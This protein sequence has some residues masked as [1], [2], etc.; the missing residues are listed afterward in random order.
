MP[1]TCPMST[2]EVVEAYNASKI[3]GAT[4]GQLV[5]QT[6]DY[7]ITNCRRGDWVQAKKG[8]VELMGSLN[9]DHPDVAGPLFRLYEYCLDGIRER[10]FDETIA[11][12]SELREA[13]EALVDQVESGASPVGRETAKT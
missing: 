9:L 8:L 5:L 10:R 11:I 6:Y 13:W 4:P 3:K 12:L 2:R 7:V 1:P